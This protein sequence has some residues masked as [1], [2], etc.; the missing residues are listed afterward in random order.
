MGLEVTPRAGGCKPAW[1]LAGGLSAPS[2]L[3]CFLQRAVI[4]V[5]AT[6]GMFWKS[7]GRAE[8]QFLKKTVRARINSEV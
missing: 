1:V 5:L 6:G 8:G 4:P 2:L 7:P 3:C